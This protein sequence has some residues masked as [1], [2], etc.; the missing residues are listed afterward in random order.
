MLYPWD[1][2]LTDSQRKD[3]AELA[4]RFDIGWIEHKHFIEWADRQIAG[5][6]EPCMAIIDLA[7]SQPPPNSIERLLFRDWI[8]SMYCSDDYVVGVRRTFLRLR[9]A[10]ESGSISVGQAIADGLDLAFGVGYESQI[11]AHFSNLDVDREVCHDHGDKPD[12][13]K[14]LNA[15]TIE[16]LQNFGDGTWDF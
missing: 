10:V 2:Q 9:A 14:S 16:A 4:C 13:L 12:H 15:C 7:I 11:Y 8:G 6:D 5:S 3:I 1:Q